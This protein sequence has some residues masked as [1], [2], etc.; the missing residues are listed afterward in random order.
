MTREEEDAVLAEI[1][2]FRADLRRRAQ[3]HAR[4]ERE[5]S[6]LDRRTVDL[7]RLELPQIRALISQR[8]ADARAEPRLSDVERGLAVV[9]ARVVIPGLATGEN[10]EPTTGLNGR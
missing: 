1:A 5:A 7:S 9:E 8:Y 10:P 2:A 3:N 4:R 6:A